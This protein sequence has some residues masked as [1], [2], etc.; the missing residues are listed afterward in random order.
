MAEL[1]EI[2][3]VRE[4]VGEE[5]GDEVAE[6]TAEGVQRVCR[7]GAGRG[8]GGGTRKCRPSRSMYHLSERVVLLFFR[9]A[10]MSLQVRKR[11]T[12]VNTFG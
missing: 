3:E 11:S 2:L 8:D 1:E 9:E 7:G 5:V 10:N 4:E 12:V 6:K